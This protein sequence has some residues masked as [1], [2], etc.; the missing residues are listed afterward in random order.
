LLKPVDCS[1]V[2]VHGEL[3]TEDAVSV[4]DRL[5]SRDPSLQTDT[6]IHSVYCNMH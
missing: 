2:P 5:F 4:E 1:A 3:S 6:E